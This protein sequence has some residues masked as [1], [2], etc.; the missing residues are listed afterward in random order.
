MRDVR[1]GRGRSFQDVDAARR[2]LE[3]R[4]DCTGSIGVIGYCMG[5]G[6]A[7]VL[8]PG[9]GFAASCVNYGAV[10]K[11]AGKALAGA[12][13]VVASYGGKDRTLKNAA[14]KLERVLSA[15]GVEHDVK[16]YP[17][18]GH[19]FLNDHEGAQDHVPALFPI[20]GKVMGISGLHGASAE[21]ARRRIAAFFGE[22]L[23]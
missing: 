22:H 7:L 17:E 4:G 2:F 11:D 8:A 14:A 23:N 5:G 10:P 6:F 9:H 1:A 12:C 20:V 13:P 16:E 3:D 15:I 19:G 18:A 21:D